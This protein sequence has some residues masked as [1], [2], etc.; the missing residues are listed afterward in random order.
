MI[1]ARFPER[2]SARGRHAGLKALTAFMILAIVACSEQKALS[3]QDVKSRYPRSAALMETARFLA[4]T[5]VAPESALF[6]ASQTQNYIAYKA[7]VERLW[8]QYREKQ[9]LQIETWRDKELAAVKTR[10]LFY[11]FSGPDILNA[12]A[13]FP[14]AEEV[15][16]FGLE[17][18]GVVPDP[19]AVPAE[20]V[21]AGLWNITKALRTLL[22][23]NLFRTSEMQVDLKADS[24]NSITGIMMFFLCRSGFEILD[25]RP[26]HM[27]K[28]AGFRDGLAPA[29]DDMPGIEF[30]FRKGPGAPVKMARYFSIDL[31]DKS[32][33][34]K[35]G[36]TAHLRK[37][38]Q[39]NTFLKSASYLLSYAYFATVRNFIL[40]RSQWVIQG[41]S[42]IPLKYFDQKQWDI[43]VY[44]HYRVLEMFANRYQA[45]LHK[46]VKEQ[47]K[48]PLPY[49]F[50]Y[51][52]VPRS[53]AILV[54]RRK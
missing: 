38:K 44:G 51:G 11:P 16:M 46:L 40:D 36:V 25:I 45:D 6:K 20:Q 43:A 2:V 54:A 19:R 15:L 47:S 8:S 4:G 35:P 37:Y 53:S 42:G 14:T 50:D 30:T 21:H 18:P 39:F 13:F 5:D 49:S 41:D 1:T 52:F 48:G 3:E 32:L 28:D 29:P 10:T 7:Q 34:G 22:S 31:S 26:V 23:L 17:K 33:E 9:M 24:Y 27:N 12:M